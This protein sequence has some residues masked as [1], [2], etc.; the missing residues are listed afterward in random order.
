MR[1]FEL[2]YSAIDEIV[3][4]RGVKISDMNE[5]LSGRKEYFHDGIHF[6]PMGSHA[7]SNLVFETLWSHV[8]RL[9]KLQ[10]PQ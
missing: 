3:G 9:S 5:G 7:A 8:I 4:D 10:K 2:T 6:S 1:A